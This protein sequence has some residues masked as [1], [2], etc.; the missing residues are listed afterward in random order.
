MN[1]WTQHVNRDKENQ[2]MDILSVFEVDA[3]QAGQEIP[4]SNFII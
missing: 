2:L 3:Y 4:T 1:Q